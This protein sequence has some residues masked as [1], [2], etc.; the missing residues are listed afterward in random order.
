MI[1]P[2][3]LFMPP[4]MGAEL[5]YSFIIIV[6]S[7]M[8]YFGTKELY[9]LSSHKGIKYFRQAFLFFG[10]AYFF[11]SVIMY[12]LFMFNFNEI[13]EI[14]PMFFGEG[15][16]FLFLYFSSMA[17]FSLLYSVM[18]KKWNNDSKIKYVLHFLSFAIAFLSIIS[19]NMVVRAGITLLLF[20]IV[21]FTIY[22][23]YKEGKN[24]KKKNHLY[25]I[26]MLLFAFFLLNIFDILIPN[27]LT[28]FKM[29]IYLA[30]ITVF[31]L[32]LYKVLKRTGN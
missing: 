22:E 4:E 28:E 17:V 20:T 23:V 18:W 29:F 16:L 1:P 24:K 13:L 25:T 8:V 21:L 10:L 26:Y 9:E 14:S 32:I 3:Q 15:T 2:M 6:C 27:F 19:R 11:R 7:L 30:S 5:I 31:L 12:A